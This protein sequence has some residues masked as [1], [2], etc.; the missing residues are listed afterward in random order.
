MRCLS[1]T[2]GDKT[3]FL[4]LCVTLGGNR[5]KKNAQNFAIEGHVNEGHVDFRGNLLL[6]N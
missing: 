1:D 6:Q 2:R 4:T 5:S 3:D